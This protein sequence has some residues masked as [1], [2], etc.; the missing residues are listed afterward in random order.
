MIRICL[1]TGL[2]HLMAADIVVMEDQPREFTYLFRHALLHD[3]AYESILYSQ[4]RELHRRVAQRI[5]E[6]K[7]RPSG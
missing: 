1:H 6:L 2:Q 4:R 7:Y 5:E 3:I